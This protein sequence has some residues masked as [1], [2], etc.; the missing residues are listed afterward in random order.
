KNEYKSPVSR[1]GFGIFSVL[2]SQWLAFTCRKDG[3]IAD[4]SHHF[5]AISEPYPFHS[6]QFERLCRWSNQASAACWLQGRSILTPPP[7]PFAHRS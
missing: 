7:L 1:L 6:Q 5:L 4:Y 3:Q 2:N